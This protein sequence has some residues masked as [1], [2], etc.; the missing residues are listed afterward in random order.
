MILRSRLWWRL[1]K[2]WVWLLG[3]SDG[4]KRYRDPTKLVYEYNKLTGKISLRRKWH[5]ELRDLYSRLEIQQSPAYRLG[6]IQRPKSLT[7]IMFSDLN[8]YKTGR[9]SL[10]SSLNS[11]TRLSKHSRKSKWLQVS[12][13]YLRFYMT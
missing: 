7:E 12:N 9:N 6:V 13:H 11:S 3:Q 5:D 1:V 2:F 10:V 8:L 4:W